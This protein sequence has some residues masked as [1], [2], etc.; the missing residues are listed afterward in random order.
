MRRLRRSCRPVRDRTPGSSR[1]HDGALPSARVCS[2]RDDRRVGGSTGYEVEAMEGFAVLRACG[3][4]RFPP[5]RCA[6]S[7]NEIDEPDRALW[8]FEDGFALLREI[9]PGLL[10]VLRA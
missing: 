1:L 2:D 3:S 5:S 4:R 10:E 8:L 9:V 6:W 7:S